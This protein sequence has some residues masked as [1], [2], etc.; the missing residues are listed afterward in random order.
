MRSFEIRQRYLDFF[1]SRGHVVTTSSSLVPQD[2]PT[3]LFTSAGMQP[4][5]PYLLGKDH[6]QGKRLVN[7]QKCFRSQDIL[8]VGDLSHTTFFEMLGNWSFGDYW[9]EEQLKWLFNFLLAPDEGLGLN[10]QKLYITAFEGNDQIPKDEE[11]ISIWQELFKKVGI[12]AEVGE[13][14]FLYG[15][16]KNWWSRAGVPEDMP[17][18][19]PGGPDSEVFYL[20]DNVSHDKK[21]GEKCHPNCSCGAFLEIA[22]SVFM[23]YQKQ[24]GS[25]IELPQKNVDFGGGLERLTSATQ[26][27]PDIF[28][29]DLFFPIVK[30]LSEIVGKN[31]GN[32]QKTDFN[33]RVVADHIKAAV[34]LIKDRVTPSNKMQGYVLRRLLRRS[35]VKINALKEGSMSFLTELVGTITQIYSGT[36]Y[37]QED[38][39]QIKQVISDE[40]NKFQKTLQKGLKE[41]EKIEKANGNIAFDLYQSYGF[42]FEILE[43]IFKEKGQIIN[44]E[45]FEKEFKKHQEKS[46][47]SL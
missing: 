39:E 35:A 32:D 22:N 12:E 15:V 38:S 29:I 7:S 21:Y 14:I 17:E 9:K 42:P 23:Q 4:M 26:N 16:D 40:L 24:N 11:T 10:P 37:F 13:R 6:P 44:K 41:I 8:E 34:F 46:R 30:K 31:Y 28:K 45:E 27:Q 25:F 3:T 19:E 5:L 43:E 36:G 2:D 33:L 20:F 18:G 1:K 47:N